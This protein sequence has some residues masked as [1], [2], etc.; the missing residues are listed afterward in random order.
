MLFNVGHLFAVWPNE[1]LG[2]E[3][4]LGQ[5]DP[6]LRTPRLCAEKSP[7]LNHKLSNSI[8]FFADLMD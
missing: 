2:V 7:A 3:S 5:L 8:R 1:L 6:Y 4:L